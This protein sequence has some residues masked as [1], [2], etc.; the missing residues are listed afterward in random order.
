[1]TFEHKIVIGP[2]EIKAVVFQCN[3]CN[4]KTSIVPEKLEAPPHRCPQ[5]HAWEWSIPGEYQEASSPFVCFFVGLKR[6]RD[7][8]SHRAGFKILLEFEEP[9]P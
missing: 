2:E 6:I 1:M 5:G 3:E 4:S 8:M 7:P 9:K